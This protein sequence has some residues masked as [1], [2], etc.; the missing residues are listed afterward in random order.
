[1]LVNDLT[2]YLRF[3]VESRQSM[4]ARTTAW[5]YGCME[6]FVL[7]NG[8]SYDIVIPKP[9]WVPQGVIKE[10]FSNC[11]N[12]VIRYPDLLTYCEGYATSNI[13]PVHHAWLLYQGQVI[14]PT[15][16]HKK[17]HYLKQVGYFGVA[18]KYEYV[19]KIAVESGYY[20]VLDNF[21]MRYPLLSG[22]HQPIDYSA[23]IVD[24][25]T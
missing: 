18:F 7:R 11:L 3:V 23:N 19:T 2:D 5:A 1:M 8:Q 25:P 9:K 24:A 17:L 22:D 13:M 10:C 14:D 21:T 6:D 12:C 20:G 15:W 16:S 4:G